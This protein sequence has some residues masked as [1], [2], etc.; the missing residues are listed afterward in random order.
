LERLNATIERQMQALNH[1]GLSI[2]VTDH[3]RL[4]FVGE[5][6]QANLDSRHPVTPE[7]LFQIGSISK[8]FTSIVLLQ[9]QEQ[10]LL[11]IDQPV[12]RY[13]PWFEIQSDYAPITLRHL[14][15][16]TASIIEGTDA[17]QSAFTETWNLRTTRATAPPGETFYYSNSGYKVL[18]LVLQAILNQDMAD[19]LT[20][21]IFRPLGMDRTQAV[22]SNTIRPLLAVGYEAFYDDRPLPSGGKLAPATWFETD[23][24]DGAISSNAADMCRYLRA[25]LN[26]GANLLAPES[27]EQLTQALI[28]TGDG[29]HGEQ[30]TLGLCLRQD[31]GHQIISHSGG[32]VGYTADLIADMDAGLGVIVLTNG[33]VGPDKI[34]QYALRLMRAALEGQELPEFPRIDPYQVSNG[35]AYTGYYRSAEKEFTIRAQGEHLYMQFEGDSI[36]LE[37]RSPERFLVP[38]PAFELYLLRFGR[39]LNPA[40]NDKAQIIEAFHGPDWYVQERYQGETHFE[41]PPEWQAYTGHYRAYNPW[42]TNFRVLIQKDKLVLILP[43]SGL[44]EPLYQTGSSVFRIGEDPRSPEFIHFDVFIDGKAQ[45]ANLS[46]GAYCRIFTP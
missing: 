7:T 30:Y 44:E 22:I 9:L 15:S 17:T 33:P 42:M 41:I 5:Y 26:R 35:E 43:T 34:S 31:D 27:F 29:L 37:S 19:I 21:H 40:D 46:G 10:G 6:G 24:A 13:L 3:Q 12:T 16:H 36:R 45:Q 18:G 2:G 38:H 25:L 32:T 23:T 4:L 14:M 1:P 20:E 11:S 8:A 28:P 39:E